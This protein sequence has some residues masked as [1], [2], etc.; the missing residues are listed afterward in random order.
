MSDT[1]KQSMASPITGSLEGE[2][3]KA[4]DIEHGDLTPV[5]Y[6][7]FTKPEK[8][9]VVSIV[10]YASVFSPLSSF[11]YYPT[12]SAVAEAI[13][14]F[15]SKIN[16][17]ITSYMIVSDVEPMIMGSIKDKIGRRPVYLLMFLLC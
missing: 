2:T 3:E 8:L 17:T 16:L 4:P 12:L 15:L 10:A 9:G 5:P 7:I 11:I 6:S 13:H 1:H 14:T